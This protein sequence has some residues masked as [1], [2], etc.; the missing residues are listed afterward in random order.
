[1]S[2]TDVEPDEVNPH[3]DPR[4][5]FLFSGHMID[6]PGRKVE[7]FPPRMEAL[8]GKR[9]AEK[10]DEFKAG[11]G[12]LALC[13][14]A[15]GGDTL[16]AEACLERGLRLELRI[17]FEEPEFLRESVDFAGENW[18][19]RFISVRAHENTSLFIAADEFGP[20]PVDSNPYERNNL[21]LLESA[22]S[23]GAEKVRFIC[24]WNRE[25]GDGPGGTQHMFETV[26]KHSGKASVIDT[27]DLLAEIDGGRLRG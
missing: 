17:P 1:M 5:V 18:R 25:S 21:W 11:P 26:K 4:K 16:F 13:G 15:C 8:A 14:G 3:Y 23:H 6:A 10:L 2:T 19:E 22:L 24:L 9:I 7:R 27:N 20:A 12:D